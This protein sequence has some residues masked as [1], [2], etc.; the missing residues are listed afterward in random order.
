M[1]PPHPPPRAARLSD[2]LEGAPDVEV[3]ALA[4]DSRRV[5]PGALFFCVPG[6]EADGHDFAPD[7]IR[8]G[9]AALV[10][11]RPLGLGVPEAV[12]PDARAAMA[13]MAARMPWRIRQFS[14]ILIVY[15]R[16]N[17]ALCC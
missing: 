16:P 13:P 3:T 5:T 1:T 15:R 8:R 10:V 2:L 12:V 4:Y 9:A 6:F 11:E 7:A 14:H 17:E